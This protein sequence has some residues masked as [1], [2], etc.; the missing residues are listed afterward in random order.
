VK[1]ILVFATLV[2][3]FWPSAAAIADVVVAS[4]L[5]TTQLSTLAWEEIGMID[6]RYNNYNN[7]SKGQQLIPSASGVLTTVDALIG[8]YSSSPPPNYP[9]LNVSI[10]T[11]L[12]GIPI[13]KLATR[14]FP[15][16]AFFVIS[17]TSKKH[18]TTIDF[19]ASQ[20]PIVA[21]NQYLVAFETPYGVNTQNN[22]PIPYL[23]GYPETFL[24]LPASQARDGIH[25]ELFGD[26]RE[27]GISVSVVPEPS[28]LVLATSIFAPFAAYRRRRG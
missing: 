26:P 3:A 6:P 7:D 13:T 24:G 27:I 8:V 21:G 4:N 20:I 23:A 17:D 19:S 11:S 5:P 12:A 22:A 18:R 9:P 25:W 15:E 28:T 16:T 10:Y 14:S 1:R 2:V